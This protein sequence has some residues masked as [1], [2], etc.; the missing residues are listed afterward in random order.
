MGIK[1]KLRLFGG[2]VLLLNLWAIGRFNLDP[3]LA[4]IFTFGFA[5]AFEYIAVRSVDHGGSPKLRAGITAAVFLIGLTFVTPSPSTATSQMPT[6][7]EQPFPND[8]LSYPVG[9]LS[10]EQFNA[11]QERWQQENPGASAYTTELGV[12][13]NAVYHENSA[14]S[15]RQSLDESW[16]RVQAAK[17]ASAKSQAP[18]YIVD[19]GLL[20]GC[21]DGY[22]DH[23]ADPK[24]CALP[25][26]AARMLDRATGRRRSRDD[27]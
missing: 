9:S 21:P 24:K 17:V 6:A 8:L 27:D 26:V 13:L 22:V 5:A 20:G 23:P 14:L 16:R 19:R 3:L 15:L 10:T 18:E 25:V 12:E 7:A 4:G 2:A 11:A 1:G